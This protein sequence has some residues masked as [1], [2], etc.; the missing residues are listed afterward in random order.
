MTL[1]NNDVLFNRDGVFVCYQVII[2]ELNYVGEKG[3]VIVLDYIAKVIVIDYIPKVIVNMITI[4]NNS[5][6]AGFPLRFVS[7]ACTESVF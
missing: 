6:Q 2:L 5:T 1:V 3:H 7:N 4:A